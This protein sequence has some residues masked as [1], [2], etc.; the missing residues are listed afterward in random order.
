[1]S[2]Q[3]EWRLGT[4]Q[5]AC[6]TQ[7]LGLCLAPV[8]GQGLSASNAEMRPDS[9]NSWGRHMGQHFPERPAKKEALL[10]GWGSSPRTNSREGTTI[11]QNTL[12][13]SVPGKAWPSPTFFWTGEYSVGKQGQGASSTPKAIPEIQQ[14]SS[15]SRHWGVLFPSLLTRNYLLK[16]C[17]PEGWQCQWPQVTSWTGCSC[18]SITEGGLEDSP[19]QGHP[20]PTPPR[21]GLQPCQALSSGDA[22]RK[23]NGSQIRSSD[24]EQ[25]IVMSPQGPRGPN[26]PRLASHARGTFL[27][28]TTGLG[29]RP[30][31]FHSK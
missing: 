4:G 25:S 26:Q 20:R 13:G 8:R 18:T 27:P 15:C 29:C 28:T 11:P 7:T 10:L 14:R 9:T 16:R 23:S 17:S 31:C 5:G 1:M 21:P 2:A 3:R 24:A 19:K 30:E 22:E 12:K 6:F